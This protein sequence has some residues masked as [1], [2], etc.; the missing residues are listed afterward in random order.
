MDN[1]RELET[2]PIGGLLWQ[3]ALPAVVSQVIASVYNIVDRMFL[4]SSDCC[5]RRS[6]RPVFR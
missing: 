2:K 3:Y 4:G 1:I 5:R 6:A